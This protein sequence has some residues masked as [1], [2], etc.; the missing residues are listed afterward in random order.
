MSVAHERRLILYIELKD[1]L[2]GKAVY[3]PNEEIDGSDIDS[4]P[5]SNGGAVW[6]K[7]KRAAKQKRSKNR[8][9]KGKA[10]RAKDSD[11]DEKWVTVDDREGRAPVVNEQEADSSMITLDS[12]MYSV[13]NSSETSMWS[14]SSSQG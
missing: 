6:G 7:R 3:D 4:D 9:G 5:G 13:R 8:K 12:G 1:L 11:A 14:T 2:S 10:T